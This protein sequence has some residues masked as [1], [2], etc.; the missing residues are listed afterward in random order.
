M[1]DGFGTYYGL[2]MMAWCWARPIR[3][4][5]VVFPIFSLSMYFAYGTFQAENWL[6]FGFSVFMT[7]SCVFYV[8]MAFFIRKYGRPKDKVFP[9]PF[10]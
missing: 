6:V 1:V 3:T 2:R 9:R 8:A 10:F 5:L 7:F 4:G